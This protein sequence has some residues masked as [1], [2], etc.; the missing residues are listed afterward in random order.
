M[1]EEDRPLDIGPAEFHLVCLGDKA[2]H[3]MTFRPAYDERGL[4]LG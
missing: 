3:M 2:A 4:T 1:L